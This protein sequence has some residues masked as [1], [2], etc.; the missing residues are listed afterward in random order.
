MLLDSICQFDAVYCVTA[1]AAKPNRSQFCP[2]FCGLYAHRSGP[3]LV[4]LLDDPA[5]YDK[6][7]PGISEEHGPKP[8]PR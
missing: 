7:L 4:R 5:V 3:I 1:H 8:S 2:S 6:I